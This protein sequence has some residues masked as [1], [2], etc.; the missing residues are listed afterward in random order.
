MLFHG[1]NRITLVTFVASVS[2]G[3]NIDS[4][5]RPLSRICAPRAFLTE[6]LLCNK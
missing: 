1:L 5:V 3:K 6:S 4:S 2:I